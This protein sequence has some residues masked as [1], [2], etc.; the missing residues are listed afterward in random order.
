MRILTFLTMAVEQKE[1]P[2]QTIEQDLRL[3]EDQIEEFVIDGKYYVFVVKELWIGFVK[4]LG[5]KNVVA[6]LCLFIHKEDLVSYAI[7]VFVKMCFKSEMVT[8]PYR[9]TW[10]CGQTAFSK[11]KFFGLLKVTEITYFMEYLVLF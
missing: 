6:R 3:S 10:Y 1:I 11:I 5:F 4:V 9:H 2:Y 7:F 8:M